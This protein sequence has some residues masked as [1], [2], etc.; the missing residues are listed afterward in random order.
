[1]SDSARVVVPVSLHSIHARFTDTT[2]RVYQ[3]FPPRI[4]LPS[5]EVGKLVQ[6][7]SLGRMSWIKPSFNWMMYRSGYATKLNQEVVLA[8]DISRSGFN[9]ALEHAAL[10]SYQAAVHGSVEQWRRELLERPVRV[11]W[12][13]ERD[14]RLG[15]VP[16]VRTIQVGLSGEALRLYAQE[17]I[18]RIEDATPI[19]RR[20]ASLLSAGVMLPPDD[21]PHRQ[22]RRYEVPDEAV[23]LCRLAS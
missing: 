3:A 10:S 23:R 21:L 4:A 22:E 13:P 1:M 11:Q 8:L 9:W 17:W 5:L 14:W 12:D 15:V 7:F 19:A 20:I 6:P 2:I 16:G 18:I